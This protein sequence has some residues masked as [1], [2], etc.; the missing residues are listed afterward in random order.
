MRNNRL[1]IEAK[2]EGQEMNI[3][4]NILIIISVTLLV[5]IF[6]KPCNQGA[7]YNEGKWRKL[8]GNLCPEIDRQP[9]LTSGS[10]HSLN[11]CNNDFPHSSQKS[12]IFQNVGLVDVLGTWNA[13]NWFRNSI[14][15]SWKKVSSPSRHIA[16]GDLDGDFT[17]D[18]VGT[19]TSG[20]WVKFSQTQVWSKLSSRLPNCVA[21]GY[22]NLDWKKD[23]LASWSGSY[24]FYRDSES[25]SWTKIAEAAD[26]I[27]A[28]DIDGDHTDDLIGVYSSGLWVRFSSVGA[29]VKLATSLPTGIASG[30]MNGDRR[31]DV[32]ASWPDLGV[33]Y[34]NSL[35]GSWVKM[36]S[37]AD[38][39]AAGDVTGD[40]VDDLIGVWSSGLYVKYATSGR[41][42]KLTPLTPSGLDAGLL[43][44]GNWDA[45]TVASLLPPEDGFSGCS[46]IRYLDLSDVGPGGRNFQYQEEGNPF[47]QDVESDGIVRTPGPGDPKFVYTEQQNLLPLEET[48]QKK[49]R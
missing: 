10:N 24:V 48:E 37:Y 14:N 28:G 44:T 34:R 23:I 36:S 13:G 9:S 41:W 42:L 20:L 19:W 31:D 17:A 45:G 46:E 18:L 15:G 35:S 30:D 38:S 11:I 22:M 8:N 40:F 33:F 27:A 2:R 47:P 4:T 26:L 1:S 29:W 3:R 16:C 43:R 39:I 32:L 6:L 5:S 12:R 21:T 25:G 49:K 7:L